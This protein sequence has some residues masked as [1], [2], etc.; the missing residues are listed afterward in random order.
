MLKSI[1]KFQWNSI[2]IYTYIC[3]HS[4]CANWPETVD[5]WK[6]TLSTGPGK[7]AQLTCIH[8]H[9]VYIFKFL[10]TGPFLTC[11][12]FFNRKQLF[13]IDTSISLRV[14][15]LSLLQWSW[16]LFISLHKKLQ[17]FITY[18]NIMKS[19]FWITILSIYYLFYWSL[20]WTIKHSNCSYSIVLN[21]KIYLIFFWFNT[22]S[23]FKSSYSLI[24]IWG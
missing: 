7:F 22:I 21:P 9:N 23:T 24:S 17:L 15:S 14:A 10:S 2:Y 5:R 8:I 18:I 19:S 3:M 13:Q 1:L 16:L 11:R 4:N 6:N 12:P 20:S